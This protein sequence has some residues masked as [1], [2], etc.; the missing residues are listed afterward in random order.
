MIKMQNITRRARCEKF[1]HNNAV[2]RYPSIVTFG[3]LDHFQ[4][5]TKVYTGTVLVPVSTH[6]E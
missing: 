3:E 4:Y 2:L 5:V 6:V 1:L